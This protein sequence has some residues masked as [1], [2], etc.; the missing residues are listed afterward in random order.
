MQ[1][2]AH[3]LRTN[4]ETGLNP[5]DFD[6]R[7]EQYGS[8]KKPPTKRTPFITLFLGALDDFMLKLLLVCAIV[9]IS[10]EVGFSDEDHRPTGKIA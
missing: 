10:I 3:S 2:L 4:Y 1:Q 7:D 8:N 9:S 6:Q 5:I